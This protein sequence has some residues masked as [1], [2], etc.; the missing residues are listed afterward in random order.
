MTEHRTWLKIDQTADGQLLV[1]DNDGNVLY[2]GPRTRPSNEDVP[3]NKWAETLVSEVERIARFAMSYQLK[4][5]P[6]LAK[7]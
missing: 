6:E 5:R 4:G 7:F 2:C 1:K 3:D